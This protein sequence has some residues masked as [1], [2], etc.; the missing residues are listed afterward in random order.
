[1]KGLSL[2]IRYILIFIIAICIFAFIF[3][4]IASSTILS[5]SY[6]L[7]KLEETNYYEGMYN[8]IQSNFEKYIGQSGLDDINLRDIIT[9]E[10]VKNDV[11]I[12]I[13]NIYDGADE[14]IDVTEI[15]TNLRT[16]IDELMKSQGLK[17][18]DESAIDTYINTISDEYTSTMIHTDYEKNINNV[19]VKILK[20]SQKGNKVLLVMILVAVLLVFGICY[21]RPFKGFS[22]AGVALTSIGGLNIFINYFINAKIKIDTITILSETFSK[23]IRT[24]LNDVMSQVANYGYILL[25]VG[26]VL[27][28]FGNIIDSIKYKE[29]EEE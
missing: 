18:E 16:K 20:Y 5:K 1:M 25:I 14:K 13:N 2:I 15:K 12:M 29:E 6:I 7:S 10:K 8:E 21:K 19:L 24:V 9:E 3:L 22:S 17:A 28:I 23:S 26:I 27:I 4:N 11:N